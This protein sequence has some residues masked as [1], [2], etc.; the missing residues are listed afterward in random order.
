[1]RGALAATEE[2]FSL[3]VDQT[4]PIDVFSIVEQQGV[5]LLFGPLGNALGVFL[6]Q[7]G[8]AGILINNQRPRSVQRLTAAHEYG[9]YRLGHASSLDD[10]ESVE[11]S[12]TAEQEVEAQAFAMD[13][14]MPL[15][16][17]EAT[18]ESLD[19]PARS[20]ETT[21]PEAYRLAL[22]M[23]VSYRACVVQLRAMEKLSK[24][25]AIELLSYKP[26]DLKRIVNQGIGPLDPWADVW[27]LEVA[28]SGRSIEVRVRDEIRLKLPEKPS[29]GY[30]WVVDEEGHTE[31]VQKTGEEFE[32]LKLEDGVIGVGGHRFVSFRALEPGAGHLMLKLI[33]T[34]ENVQQPRRFSVNL[35]IFENSSGG[36]S[37]GLRSGIQQVILSG[38]QG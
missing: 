13:F 24:A 1:M 31:L 22:S 19:L 16:L 36:E 3:G 6:Q 10:V 2:L 7:G 12:V 23:G 21:A 15:E 8:V 28:D 26:K 20:E 37:M 32:A 34:W 25:R 27:P 9:H 11:G 35:T 4:K 14:I 38:V 30:R 18:W 17:V 29:T 5:W 33:R